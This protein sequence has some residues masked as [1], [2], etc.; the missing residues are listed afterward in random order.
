MSS[1]VQC[2]TRDGREEDLAISEEIRAIRLRRMLAVT[3]LCWAP[4]LMCVVAWLLYMEAQTR[5][6]AGIGLMLAVLMS[7][8]AIGSCALYWVRHLGAQD[9]PKRQVLAAVKALRQRL[10]FISGH[11]PE[12]DPYQQLHFYS[13][14]YGFRALQP[15]VNR[16]LGWAFA[17]SAAAGLAVSVLVHQAG[18]SWWWL[19]IAAIPMAVGVVLVAKLHLRHQHRRW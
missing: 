1:N 16:I 18:S 7:A 12:E 4:L 14:S 10:R 9:S 5:E 19:L 15:R 17:L 8:M 11:P 2:E 13:E 6:A 3:M